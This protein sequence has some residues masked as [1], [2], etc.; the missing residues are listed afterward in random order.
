MTRLYKCD[1][2]L[3]DDCLKVVEER[4]QVLLMDINE[5][6]LDDRLHACPKCLPDHI[7][8]QLDLQSRGLQGL[9][10]DE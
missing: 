9:D 1:L 8:S 3:S 10:E 5:T 4:H 7:S 2:N 6:D